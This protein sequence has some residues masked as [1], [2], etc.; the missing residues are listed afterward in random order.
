MTLTANMT[1]CNNIIIRLF[2]LPVMPPFGLLN[3]LCSR[4]SLRRF[5][6]SGDAGRSSNGSS[7]MNCLCDKF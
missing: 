3:Y 2:E 1:I 5:S 7:L 6:L 4:G